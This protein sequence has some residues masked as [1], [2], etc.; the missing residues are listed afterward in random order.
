MAENLSDC[1]GGYALP[2]AAA[3]LLYVSVCLRNVLM[4]APTF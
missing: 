1:A 2:R 4:S 3:A